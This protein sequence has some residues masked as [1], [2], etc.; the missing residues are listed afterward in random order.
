MQR[1]LQIL[2][3]PA[4]TQTANML[5]QLLGTVAGFTATILPTGGNATIAPHSAPDVLLYELP[6][7]GTEGLLALQA[8]LGR[9][10]EDTPAFVIGQIDS[11]S[12]MRSLM[13]MGVRDVLHEPLQADELQLALT[14]VLD[15]RREQQAPATQLD[16]VASFFNAHSGSGASLLAA[17]TATSLARRHQARV[18]LIDLDFQFGKIAHFL[19]IKPQSHV[20]D[21]LRDV[22][23]L[24]PVFLKALMCTHES[25]V[26]VLAAPPRLM[27]LE[28]SP[29]AVRKLIAT[30]AASYDVV[31]LDLPR[32]VSEWTLE[33]LACSDKILLLTQNN[34]GA[35][36]DTRRLLDYLSAHAELLPEHIEVVNSRAMS[37]LTSTSIEQMKKVL[38][39]SRLHRMRND[40]AA[41][42]AA[43]DQGLPLFRAAPQSALTEDCERLAWHIWRLRHPET[44]GTP[45][46]APRW[47]DRL[48]GLQGEPAIPS[49]PESRQP[50]ASPAPALLSDT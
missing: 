9:L 8:L 43:E 2:A 11:P 10:P 48:R 41:A 27:P 32:V 12:L 14:R 13:Q 24:D 7:I 6:A 19:D 42:L 23:R 29:T 47:F 44:G 31:I 25:G 26:Q 20:L 46:R 45:S 34:L 22:H 37:R 15:E 5:R 1:T 16:T 3:A 35:M 39:V 30:A 33:A 21:A 36:R 28:C 50:R 18:A 4:S 49:P 17:N 40:Y 38:G